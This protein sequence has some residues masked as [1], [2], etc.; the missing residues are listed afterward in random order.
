MKIIMFRFNHCDISGVQ[1]A[2]ERPSVGKYGNMVVR[3]HSAFVVGLFEL[4][5]LHYE[6]G[7]SDFMTI[8]STLIPVDGFETW[9]AAVS[10]SCG[11]SPLPLVERVSRHGCVLKPMPPKIS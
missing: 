5:L 11:K 2:Y 10:D 6:L 8:P 9:R 1:G 4:Q 3:T 7:I